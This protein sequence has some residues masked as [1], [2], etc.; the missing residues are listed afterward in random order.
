MKNILAF[1]ASN[2][3]NSINL[4]LLSAAI[5]KLAGHEIQETDIRDYPM[6][7]YSTVLEELEGFP[8]TAKQLQSKFIQ[9]DAFVIAIPEHNGSMPAVFKNV[10]DWLSRLVGGGAPLFGDK[11][12]LLMSTSPGPRGGI[13]NLQT[14]TQI[15][16]YW[17]ADVSG[18]F[19][20][21]S[22]YENFSDGQL[23]EDKDQ[24]LSEA[25]QKFMGKL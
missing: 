13:T 22:F 2:S 20:L 17:G 9:A 16:P 23:S 4:Q 8:E 14:L 19:S 6:P 21:G 5:G 1:S 18:T 25:I 24:Q 3:T 10:I 7:M 12:V 15:M 11:P